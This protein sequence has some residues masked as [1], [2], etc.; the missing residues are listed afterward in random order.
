M[1]YILRKITNKEFVAELAEVQIKT[2]TS[3]VQKTKYEHSHTK[4]E[5][6]CPVHGSFWKT[7]SS[8]LSGSLCPAC[9]AKKYQSEHLMKVSLEYNK[10]LKKYKISLIGDFARGTRLK[11]LCRVCKTEF[12]SLPATLLAGKG[13]PCCAESPIPATRQR[14]TEEEYAQELS[15]TGL[16]LVPG[17]FSGLS[18]PADFVCP[19]HGDFSAT[20]RSA[21][22]RGCPACSR[23][24]QG[25]SV[26]LERSVWEDRIREKH[27]DTVRLLGQYLGCNKNR[28]YRFKCYVCFNTWKAQLPAVAITG[29][30]CPHCAN[31]Q[32][33]KAGFRVKTYEREGITFRVQGWEYQA[34][35][36]ILE[37]RDVKAKDI[38]TESTSK[39]PVFEYKFGRRKHNYYPDMYIPRLNKIV[40]VKS[41]YT[42]GLTCGR[43][44]TRKWK[45]NQLKAKAVISAGY[46]F[47][48]MLMTAAGDRYRLPKG[49]YN[50]SQKEVLTWIAYHNGSYVGKTK[51]VKKTLSERAADQLRQDVREEKATAEISA[52]T[53]KRVR[54]FL[55]EE[56]KAKYAEA[57]TRTKAR[58][59]RRRKARRR[60]G[61][62]G[63]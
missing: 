27:G 38:L 22:S 48:M 42:L 33:T 18:Y 54:V 34:I 45:V 44:S 13:C 35:I 5:F 36:W 28:R 12:L 47:S 29:T 11:H 46:R 56:T 61:K 20:A 53:N 63:V 2:G 57:K 55:D 17:T 59:P 62:S 10:K 15:Q 50:L 39:V 21:L 26:R 30:G 16:S 58:K 41:N 40:E 3:Y 19:E 37:N 24:R 23:K 7:R 43:G 14:Y 8:I 25:E 6:S 4:V 9:S 60:A 31:Q 32:K 1:V 51:S 52:R 49:W